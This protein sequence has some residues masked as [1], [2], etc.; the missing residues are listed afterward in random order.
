M[1][2]I[3]AEEPSKGRPNPEAEAVEAVEQVA[4]ES[5]AKGMPQ[6]DD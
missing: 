4:P 3:W 2:K 5:A 6:P 1:P